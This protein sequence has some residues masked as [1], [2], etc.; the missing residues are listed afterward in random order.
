[1]ACGYD[2]AP[3][4]IGLAGIK[5]P[6]PMQGIDL[7]ATS[8]TE[9]GS[10]LSFALFPQPTLNLW[11]GWNQ[12]SLPLTRPRPTGEAR[13]SQSDLLAAEVD[14][15]FA[16][17]QLRLEARQRSLH[18]TAS[19]APGFMA[20]L[21]PECPGLDPGGKRGNFVLEPGMRMS[22]GLMAGWTGQMKLVIEG[23][24]FLIDLGQRLDRGF[25]V[26]GKRVIVQDG[27]PGLQAAVRLVWPGMEAK[28]ASS[29]LTEQIRALG[30]IR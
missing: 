2:V 12:T 1:M 24:P 21:T 20:C 14:A 28:G 29:L 3:T 6:A 18:V 19:I 10:C 16:G 13:T 17:R 15:A 8:R 7:L 4:L 22:L 11:S 25:R 26:D 30:Y 5:K 27:P 23:R 9:A